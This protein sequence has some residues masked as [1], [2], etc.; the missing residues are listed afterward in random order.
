[1]AT[2]LDLVKKAMRLVGALGIGETPT[3]DEAS[4]G[5]EAL[6]SLL[7]S[8]WT[9]RLAVYSQTEDTLSWAAGQV[10]R[11]IGSGGDFNITRPVRVTSAAQTIQDIDYPINIL[12]S[13]QYRGLPDKNVDSTLITHLWYDLGADLGTLYAYPKPSVTATVLLRSHKQLQS[14]SSNTTALS[15]PPG[16]QRAVEYNLA[17]ELASEY[18]RQIPQQ[19]ALIA[20]TSLAA[21]RRLN[22]EV[23]QQR[24]E[25]A[26]TG[27]TWDWRTG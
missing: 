18:Q 7:D 20:S 17:L 9:Q 15:L 12:T 13:E 2:A 27:R 8:W 10:S 11:T 22:K 19:V 26:E 5:R 6:N 1:M 16:Y 25:F 14:F 23:P 21:L 4:V 3:D 24:I